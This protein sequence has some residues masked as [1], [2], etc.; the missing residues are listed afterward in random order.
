MCLAR[1]HQFLLLVVAALVVS[2]AAAEERPSILVVIGDD[3]GWKDYGCYGHPSIRTPNIDA[4]AAAGLRFTNAF[5]TTSSCSPS[6]ISILSGRY[7]RQTGAEDLHM[8]L[9]ADGILVPTPLKKSGYFTGHMLKTHYGPNGMKQFD[10]YGKSVGQFSKFLDQVEAAGD[11]PFFM[12]V[13]FR[14]AHRPYKAGALEPPHDPARVVVPPFLLD[15]PATRRDLAMYYDEIGRMDKD[16]GTMVAELKKRKRF[17]NTLI[18]FL[19]DN[20]EPFPRA[21]GTVYDSGIG[22]PLVMCW[23]KRIAAGGVHTGLA[24]VIDL[25]PTLTD[26]AGL[27]QPPTMVGRSLVPVLEDPTRA[28]REYVFAE[29]N[30]HNADEHIRCVRTKTHKLIVNAYLDKPFGHPADCSRCPSWQDLVTA[31]KRGQ[32]NRDQRQV[33]AVPRPMV[34]LYDTR[35]DPGEFRNLSSRADLAKIRGRLENVLRDWQKR[36]NDFPAS[37]R[38]RADN[39]DRITGVK[40]TRKIGPQVEQGVPKPLR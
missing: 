34:E 36:T 10:W 11:R 32:L 24:S 33:F 13:G 5:L 22:T 26:V 7:P 29:R 37:R 35:T 39:V 9:P 30:W 18:V 6:R 3:I 16:I 8:P 23:P 12:W 21:K 28:G 25:A 27:D 17:D 14:D 40:F 20:G 19:G 1:T 38:R 15:T 31:R 4:L 2:P